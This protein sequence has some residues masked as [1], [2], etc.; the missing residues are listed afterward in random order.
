MVIE[1]RR[2]QFLNVELRISVIQ[3]GIVIDVRPLQF[4][5]ASASIYITDNVLFLYDTFEGIVKSPLL[6]LTPPLVTEHVDSV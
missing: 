4:L 1:A 6:F 3:F 2:V 5:N